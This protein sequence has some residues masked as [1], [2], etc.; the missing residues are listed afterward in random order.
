MYSMKYKLFALLISLSVALPDAN[1]DGLSEKVRKIKVKPNKQH[2]QRKKIN[3]PM[4]FK[5]RHPTT[6]Y[7]KH[8]LHP[9]T[10]FFWK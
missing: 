4:L 10:N 6:E 9:K 5:K 3:L 7:L 8:G 1:A 2:Q